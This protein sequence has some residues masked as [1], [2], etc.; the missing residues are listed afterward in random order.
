MGGGSGE[1]GLLDW[2][3]GGWPC[4][5]CFCPPLG[6]PAHV[7]SCDEANAPRAPVPT[8]SAASTT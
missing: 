2:T 7:S 3:G 4:D 5:A 1:E 8:L 6:P